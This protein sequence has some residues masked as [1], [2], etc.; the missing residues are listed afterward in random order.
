[1]SGSK[2]GTWRRERIYRLDWRSLGQLL[3]EIA[4]QIA[5]ANFLPDIVVGIARGGLIPATY[6][7]NVFAV[8]DLRAM[9]VL[10]NSSDTVYSA[11]Q[12]PQIVWKSWDSALTGRLVLLVDDVSG[13]GRTFEAAVEALKQDGT[14][15]VR[16]AV[17]TKMAH[18]AFEPDFTGITLDDWIVFPWERFE[19]RDALPQSVPIPLGRAQT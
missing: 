3:E 1:M 9:S 12:Q 4:E 16:T 2:A 17:I 13:Q 10:R 14:E 19:Q 11:K 7:A 6:L 8:A 5:A 15:F 18:S